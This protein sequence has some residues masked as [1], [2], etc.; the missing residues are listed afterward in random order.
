MSGEPAAKRKRNSKWKYYRA[1]SDNE[2]TPGQRGFIATCN[3]DERKCLR[4]CLSLL[5][6]YANELYGP[7]HEEISSHDEVVSDK[8]SEETEEKSVES[9]N[10]QKNGDQNEERNCVV[11]EKDIMDEL[12]DK[13]KTESLS[14]SETVKR[15]HSITSGV[16]NCVY[17]KTTIEDPADFVYHIIK[18]IEKTKRKRWRHLIRLIPIDAICKSSLDDI[19]KAGKEIAE[20]YF[21]EPVTFAIVVHRKKNNSVSKDQIIKSLA[22]IIHST[23]EK[24]RVDLDNPERTVLV[25]VIKGLSCLS[26]T[27]HYK[28]YKKYNLS[29]LVEYHF[30]SG[31]SDTSNKEREK[32]QEQDRDKSENEKKKELPPNA[33]DSS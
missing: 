11:K 20:K 22:N 3:F 1:T 33:D 4:E 26:I 8:E 5:T 19:S 12:D 14:T 9:K 16:L 24:N 6:E 23:N 25:T 29:E 31:K 15:F 18:D 13:S 10:G 32:P 30:N 17:I 7:E 28:Q 21:K 2:M 27:M